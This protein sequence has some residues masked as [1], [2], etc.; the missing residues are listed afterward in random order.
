[1]SVNHHCINIQFSVFC[2]INQQTNQLL[3]HHHTYTKTIY[4]STTIADILSVFS[5]PTTNSTK[6]YVSQPSLRIYF[7][8]SVN[9]QPIRQS[10]MSVNH[11]CNYTFSFMSVNQHTIYTFS[12]QSTNKPF[13]KAMMPIYT[14]S[15]QSTNKPLLKQSIHSVLSQLKQNQQNNMS[16]TYHCIYTFSFQ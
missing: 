13:N 15:S 2:H 9:Q 5:Q 8:F 14:L 12:F 7:Q 11:H 10:N 16:V 1:M 6:Q 3:I 4:Q